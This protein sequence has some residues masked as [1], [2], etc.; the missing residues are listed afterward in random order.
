M[1]K[2][3]FTL[4]E[5]LAVIVILAIVSLIIFPIVTKEIASSKKDLYDIQIKNIIKAAKDMVLDDPTLLDSTHL[6]P[7]FISIEDMQSRTNNKGV[8][9]LEKGK[10]K[11]PNPQKDDGSDEFLNGTVVITYDINTNSYE[12]AYE[13]KTK[14]ELQN[15]FGESASKTIILNNDILSNEEESGLFEDITSNKYIFKGE[16]PNNYI[17]I[18]DSI[19]RIVSI[20]KDTYMMKIVKITHQTKTKWNTSGND[21]SFSNINLNVYTYLNS[22]F[23]NSLDDKVKNIIYENAT[24]N[25][26]SISENTKDIR[27]ILI[28][29]KASSFIINII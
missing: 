14:V 25:I 3:G 5:L 15:E 26:G 8:Y 21:I 27:S 6:T 24:W 19:Y 20:D 23:Y 7:T 11:N 29:E 1:K 2:R 22:D 9:Y 18:N 10:V 28:E 16:N 12:Y 13:E 4:V 17:K